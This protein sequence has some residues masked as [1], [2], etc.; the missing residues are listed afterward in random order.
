MSN[1][2]VVE[3]AVMGWSAYPVPVVLNLVLPAM[4]AL[5]AWSADRGPWRVAGDK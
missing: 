2:H 3:A 5:S 1:V 4:L